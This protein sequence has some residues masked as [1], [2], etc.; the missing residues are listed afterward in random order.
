MNKKKLIIS[1]TVAVL[2]VLAAIGGSLAWFYINESSYVDYGSDIACEAGQSLEI[3]IDG[4]KTW[5]G[6][7]TN[8]GFS[9][10]TV[11]ITGDGINMFSP[12]S[13]DETNNPTGFQGA[14]AVDENG[15]GDF[16]DIDL[17]FRTTS[18]MNV[19]LNGESYVSPANVNLGGNMFGNFSRDYIAGATRVAFIE[20][21]DDANT[22]EEEYA[23]K[24]IWAPN[25]S[26]QLTKST[27]GIYTFTASGTRET[28]Y[29][30]Q[31]E[32]G[33]YVQKEYT[34]KDFATSKF[35]AGSTGADISDGG[36]S[37]VLFSTDPSAGEFDYKKMKIR[38]WFEG[39]DREASEALAGG[40]VAAKLKFTG[41]NKA[42][43][44][45]ESQEAIDNIAYDPATNSITGVLENMYF[46]TDGYTWNAYS[47]TRP[48]LP[49]L[50]SGMTLYFR[51][52]ETKSNLRTDV[53]EIII[54]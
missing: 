4:G 31:Y 3:S 19:Y 26:Y 39:T 30:T 29:Y 1:I 14:V 2:I 27:G 45:E 54:P 16:I 46:S 50:S 33:E 34:A 17:M 36:N 23:L 9:S 44:T 22:G 42:V 8:D 5:A 51:Y 43:A 25:P 48:N 37:A 35:V 21:T 7:V 20:V 40:K 47:V 15:A 38:I 12:M 52:N 28:Y 18:K 10:S 6:F 53:K 11:D 32:E 49:V 13:I 41:I 24:M